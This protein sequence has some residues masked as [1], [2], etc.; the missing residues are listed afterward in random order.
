MNVVNPNQPVSNNS[1]T[2]D[3]PFLFKRDAAW[4]G[5]KLAHYGFAA[6]EVP[7]HSHN[8]HLITIPL[9]EGCTGEIRTADGF[10]ARAESRGSDCVIPAGHPFSASLE[11]P[12]ENLVLYVDPTLVLRAASD[13]GPQSRVEVVERSSSKDPVIT[14]VAMALLGEL[15][16]KGLGGRLYAES[17]ANVLAVH[18]LRHYTGADTAASSF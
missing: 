8:D 16:S 15:E 1:T 5:I 12:T 6:G 4:E 3:G 13:S 7:E 2:T 11:A 14:N 9:G 10:R 18:L 17:L